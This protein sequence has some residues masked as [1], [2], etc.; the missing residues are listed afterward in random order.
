MEIG[1]APSGDQR[2]GPSTL[3]DRVGGDEWF[4]ALVDRF[5]AGVEHDPV[6]RP[7]YPDDLTEPKRHLTL[8]LIQ[9]WG[10]P[11]TY[12]TERGHPQLRMRHFPFTVDQRARDAWLTHMTAAVQA[13]GLSSMD[14]LQVLSYFDRASTHM[15]NA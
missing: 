15:M 2:S 10:G 5:Y 1:R 14:E 6:L 8:F 3:Y 4:V 9:F 7:M 11:S 12:S 13:G